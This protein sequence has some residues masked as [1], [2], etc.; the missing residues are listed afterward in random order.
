M[1]YF[2]LQMALDA[3]D[4]SAS[5]RTVEAT[6]TMIAAILGR[7]E[8]PTAA[9]SRRAFALA[10]YHGH[11]WAF[12]LADAVGWERR[13]EILKAVSRV[14]DAELAHFIEVSR[15]GVSLPGGIW[16]SPQTPGPVAHCTGSGRLEWVVLESGAT[17]LT[18]TRPSGVLA[19]V[20]IS[21]Y[22]EMTF[23][24]AQLTLERPERPERGLRERHADA[25]LSSLREIVK[26]QPELAAEFERLADEVARLVIPEPPLEDAGEAVASIS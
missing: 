5:E 10:A 3:P 2:N 9:R 6:A 1:S 16:Y 25:L 7:D 13:D 23:F 11:E 20:T 22:G 12:S 8:L 24:P 19:T 26:Y 14:T 18:L 17:V 15:N 4:E 21:V